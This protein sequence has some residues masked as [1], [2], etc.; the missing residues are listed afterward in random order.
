MIKF[1][2]VNETVRFEVKLDP[3]EKAGIKFGSGMLG[4]AKKVWPKSGGEVKQP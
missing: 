1:S 2:R 3:A 4:S